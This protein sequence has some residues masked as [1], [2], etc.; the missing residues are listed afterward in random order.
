MYFSN[1]MFCFS[2]SLVSE[3]FNELFT[4]G[5]DTGRWFPLAL[6]PPKKGKDGAAAA[7]SPAV[8]SVERALA[9]A[10]LGESGP[11]GHLTPQERAA[12]KIQAHFRGYVVRKA[13]TAYKLGGV[14]SELLYSPALYGVDLSAKDQPKP[15]GRINASV[16]VLG[17]DLWVFGG[18][19]EVGRGERAKEV[20]LDDLWALDLNKL[21]GWR[22]VKLF[23]APEEAFQEGAGAAGSSDD[24]MGGSSDGD[25]SG[26]EDDS[27]SDSDSEMDVD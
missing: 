15:K 14:V 22:C 10:A 27:D 16:A 2:H 5:F 11:R 19:V 7:P 21:E 3:F 18:I 8:D 25:G 12:T 17:N 20:T 26:S 9:K 13:Y 6:R 24:E 4:F 1:A 23:S